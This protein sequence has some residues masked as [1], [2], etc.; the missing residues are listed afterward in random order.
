MKNSSKKKKL[1][2]IPLAISLAINAV[3]LVAVVIAERQGHVYSLAL[4]RRGIISVP[5]KA[6][7]DYWALN[8]WR[9]T[10]EKLHQEFD[11]V[12]FGNSI[13]RGSDFQTFF[14]T[15]KILNLG[16]TGD[17]L[18]GM[19]RRV[20]ALQA[21]MPKKIFIMA[22]TNDL[23]HL[24]IDKYV[25]HYDALLAAIH[26]SL[27]KAQIYIESIIPSNH[28]MAHYAPNDKIREANA[29]IK[30]LAQ[31]KGY[32]F[33]DL[34][35]LYAD[36]NDELP[37][38]LTT[39]GVHLYPQAYKRWADAIRPFVDTVMEEQDTHER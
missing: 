1:L 16:Y 31:E 17:N 4:E 23:V 38:N 3:L 2:L 9:N 19:L 35:S 20:P 33:I 5:D 36:K 39:D 8:S 26:D 22:G 25:Q 6:H 11:V 32:T 12:F 7:P 37:A 30:S 13:T 21:A 28:Q 18:S 14:P 10:V 15:L 34:Y 27:P 29:Q 24:S